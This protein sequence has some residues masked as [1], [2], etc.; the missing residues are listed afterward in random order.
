ME[1][2]GSAE[3]EAK[4]VKALQA[5]PN[6]V[7]AIGGNIPTNGFDTWLAESAGIGTNVQ[8]VHTKF[9]LVDPLSRRPASSSRARRTS[10]PTR[11]TPTTRTCW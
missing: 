6:V 11:P 10:A 1:D 9:M 5:R 4:Q 2:Y 8:W 3:Q 7:I